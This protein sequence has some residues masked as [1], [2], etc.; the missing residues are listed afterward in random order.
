VGY[1]VRE[2]ELQ[3]L[4]SHRDGEP[5]DR[6]QP[7]LTCDQIV[8]LQGD[9]RQVKMDDSINHYI[10]DIVEATRQ[11]DDLHVGVSPRGALALYRAAQALALVAGREFVVPDDV[12]S[13]AVPV[14]AHRVISKGYLHGGQREA[15][16]ALIERLVNEISV[17]E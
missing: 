3:V 1:P 4:T 7:V 15:V 9:V 10:L 14:L 17:P 11:C 2:V 13:L 12:K 16:E 5:V 8:S 6:L